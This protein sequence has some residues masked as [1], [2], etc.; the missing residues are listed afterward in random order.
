MKISESWL[1]SWANPDLS[2]KNLAHQMTMIGLE[3]NSIFEDGK[4]IEKIIIA[5]LIT[6]GHQIKTKIFDGRIWNASEEINTLITKNI[7]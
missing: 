3:V 7:I 4:D 2:T 1:R 5:K 6:I